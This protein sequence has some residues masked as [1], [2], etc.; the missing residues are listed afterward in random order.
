MTGDIYKVAVKDYG[1]H[2]MDF[3]SKWPSSKWPDILKKFRCSPHLTYPL[4]AR[5]HIRPKKDA[6]QLKTTKCDG[7][8]E[9]P[10]NKTTSTIYFIKKF[11]AR[12]TSNST[13]FIIKFTPEFLMSREIVYFFR[14]AAYKTNKVCNLHPGKWI[15][16]YLK[17]GII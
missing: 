2:S 7:I 17:R 13:Y 11:I 6:I 15:I 4:L 1:V 14:L 8:A 12:S 9:V 16:N 3:L 10:L 5:W